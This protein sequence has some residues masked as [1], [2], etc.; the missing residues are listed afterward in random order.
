MVNRR[1][2]LLISDSQNQPIL[3]LKQQINQISQTA[4]PLPCVFPMAA[5][6]S[7]S[8]VCIVKKM[9]LSD[10]QITPMVG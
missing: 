4:C 5:L 7:Q 6:V 9:W 2:M 3:S 10:P 8:R 1:Q